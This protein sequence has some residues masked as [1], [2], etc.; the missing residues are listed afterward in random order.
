MRSLKSAGLARTCSWSWARAARGSPPFRLCSATLAR[1]MAWHP[2]KLLLTAPLVFEL[3]A[4]LRQTIFP[5]RDVL[6]FD[7]VEREGHA[8]E[9]PGGTGAAGF[10]LS[11]CAIAD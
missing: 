6:D 3:H 10:R 7:L 8:L 4:A 11:T 9:F 2:G 1:L 5:L